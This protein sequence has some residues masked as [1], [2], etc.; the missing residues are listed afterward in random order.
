MTC[1]PF[2]DC[3]AGYQFNGYECVPWFNGYGPAIGI[4]SVIIIV[5]ILLI[6]MYIVFQQVRTK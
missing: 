6:L 2:I 5:T 1:T 4:A 3:R